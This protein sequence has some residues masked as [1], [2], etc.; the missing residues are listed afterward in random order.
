LVMGWS[1][2][3]ARRREDPRHFLT[4]WLSSFAEVP[5]IG[6]YV[7]FVF[8]TQYYVWNGSRSLFEQHAF[9]PPVPF[10]DLFGG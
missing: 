7:F 3:R 1:L 4:R 8:F 9:L 10:L 2:G 5:I 6:F